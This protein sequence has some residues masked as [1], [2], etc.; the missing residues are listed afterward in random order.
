MGESTGNFQGYRY[1]HPLLPL[2]NE[3]LI[4]TEQQKD[5]TERKNNKKM[6]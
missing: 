6:K 5:K 4:I 3:T 1:M 2:R